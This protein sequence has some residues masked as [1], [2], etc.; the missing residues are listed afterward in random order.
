MSKFWRAS[1]DFDRD[2]E[3]KSLWIGRDSM[4]VKQRTGFR[5]N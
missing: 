4:A 5:R 3:E 2:F 1:D